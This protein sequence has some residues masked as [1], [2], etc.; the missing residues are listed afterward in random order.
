MPRKI[1]YLHH[2]DL[3][4]VSISITNEMVDRIISSGLID[5]LEFLRVV[6][7]GN[8]ISGYLNKRY[9]DFPNIECVHVSDNPK[10]FEL[11]TAKIMKSF[12]KNNQDKTTYCL[13]LHNKGSSKTQS[14][15]SQFHY[16]NICDWRNRMMCFLV[17]KHEEVFS[18]LDSGYSS[19]GCDLHVGKH[20]NSNSH[21]SG[22]FW[23]TTS[24][25]I[26]NLPDITLS[27]DG[28]FA[29]EGWGVSDIGKAKN[30]YVHPGNQ[31]DLCLPPHK[32]VI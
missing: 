26:D 12:C 11:A 19:V 24:N 8:D 29:V 18:S 6:N 4:P 31:Y 15:Q 9:S 2:C 32:Y 14:K 23:W 21:Y 20:G 25:V 22:N 30:M 17:D 1:C 3:D 10:E 16:A 7:I 28:V 27:V 5:E 13:Y